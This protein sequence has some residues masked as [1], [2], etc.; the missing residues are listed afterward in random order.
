MASL[1]ASDYRAVLRVVQ[2][3]AA[4][5]DTDQFARRGVR[6][7]GNLVA[8]ELTTLSVCD[9][10]NDRRSVVSS[11]AG[12]ISAADRAAFD[13]H[14][15][16]HPLVRYHAIEHGRGT[17]RISDSI[18]FARFRHSALFAEYYRPIGIDHVIA[19]PLHVNDRLLVSFVLN[20]KGRDFSDH[21]RALLD[22]LAGSL[23]ELYR[24]TAALD[25]ARRAA[26]GLGELMHST[27]IGTLRL[28]PGGEVRGFSPRAAEQLL[29][30]WGVRIRRGGKLPAELAAYLARPM[31]CTSIAA[32]M[33]PLQR[34]TFDR[35]LTVRT[36]PAID[37]AGGLLVLL[38]E[39]A[40][41]L[42]PPTPEDWP[43]S[44]RQQQVL[45][46]VAAGKTD[47]DISTILGISARTVG[48][49][50]QRIYERL[51]VETRTAAVM[52]LRG[53]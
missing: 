37:M 1:S 4:V 41:D 12:A 10:A 20:R 13:R 32:T 45:H 7:L 16:E 39:E 52:R 8:S 43:L 51:G 36:Y 49:H 17:R 9:L 30:F 11:P 18:P 27:R 40:K 5:D 23:G 50:L 3:L 29:H 33:P 24:H 34:A 38:D 14:F 22:A 2:E 47:R 28:G 35:R 21:E 31:R 46:W 19:M 44:A 26:R 25:R 6:L 15:I 42:A 48:K 53:R